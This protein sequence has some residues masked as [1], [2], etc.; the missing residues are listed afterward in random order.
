MPLSAIIRASDCPP[1]FAYVVPPFAGYLTSRSQLSTQLKSPPVMACSLMYLPR[2]TLRALVT[3]GLT[4]LESIR[5]AIA[6]P[7]EGSSLVAGEWTSV[8]PNVNL[9]LFGLCQHG[10]ERAPRA[11][12][13][14]GGH[15]EWT[16]TWEAKGGVKDT[17]VDYRAGREALFAVGAEV[18]QRGVRLEVALYRAKGDAIGGGHP[19]VGEVVVGGALLSL[20]VEEAYAIREALARLWGGGAKGVADVEVFGLGAAN[21][22]D[23]VLF[24]FELA[25]ADAHV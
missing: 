21:L 13:V 23:V 20:L 17:G 1:A 19:S 5:T 12:D 9:G 4:L 25:R 14:V 8:H 15:Y 16:L 10:G 11:V 3:I 22:A 6:T 18:L 2:I 24:F 7:L